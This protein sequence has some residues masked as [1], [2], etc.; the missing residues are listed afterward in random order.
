VNFGVAAPTSAWTASVKF[1]NVEANQKPA[2]TSAVL[3]ATATAHIGTVAQGPTVG[4]CDV[5]Y[6]NVVLDVY[7]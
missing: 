5:F 6:D 3:D 1:D 4:S 7:Q 2:L